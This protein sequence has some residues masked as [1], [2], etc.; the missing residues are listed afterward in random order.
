MGSEGFYT[1]VNGDAMR[2]ALKYEL[3]NGTLL[4]DAFAATTLTEVMAG[5]GLTLKLP[6]M[7]FG[8]FTIQKFEPANSGNRSHID[9]EDEHGVAEMR[10]TPQ[11]DSALVLISK[12]DMS[13]LLR[14]HSC[15]FREA[16]PCVLSDALILALRQNGVLIENVRAQ[17]GQRLQQVLVG[18][19]LKL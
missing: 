16:G 4:A 17:N 5:F 15:D 9:D 6:G 14:H 10:S 11:Y 18:R 8:E 19:R 3:W 12:S 13:V 1:L 2:D 7:G